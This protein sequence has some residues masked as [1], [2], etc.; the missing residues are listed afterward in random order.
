M[1][2]SLGSAR[3]GGG[4]LF[5]SMWSQAPQQGNQASSVVAQSHSMSV[6]R[7]PRK[8]YEASQDLASESLGHHPTM[9]YCQAGHEASPDASRTK[10]DLLCQ[11]RPALTSHR[12]CPATCLSHVGP[13]SS[14]AFPSLR[15]AIGSEPLPPCLLTAVRAILFWLLQFLS[16]A[17]RL[18][19]GM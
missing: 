9:F 2:G 12:S 5:L 18:E 1:A 16:G 6:P 13:W 10:R 15:E 7:N 17:G 14:G 3:A 19:A 8:S 4:G 11:S